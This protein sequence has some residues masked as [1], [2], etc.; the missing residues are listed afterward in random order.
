MKSS[1]TG[2]IFPDFFFSESLFLAAILASENLKVAGDIDGHRHLLTT[3]SLWRKDNS[4]GQKISE[5]QLVWD[6]AQLTSEKKS[7]LPG[8]LLAA[9]DDQM[10]FFSP[11][12]DECMVIF[13]A[14]KASG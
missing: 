13:A 10:A 1:R 4:F 12:L 7:C 6:F 11:A 2:T 14:I 5:I 3:L 9:S 8:S